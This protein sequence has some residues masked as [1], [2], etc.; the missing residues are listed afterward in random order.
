MA[1]QTITYSDKQAMG[2]Q[3]SIPDE[4]KVTDSDMNEIKSVVNN[5]ASIL[6]DITIYSSNEKIVGTWVDGTPIYRLAVTFT[7]TTM[8]TGT[9]TGIYT[10]PNVKAIIDGHF[11][12]YGG[13]SVAKWNDTNIGYLGGKIAYFS[14]SY[15][16][17]TNYFIVDYLK[18][19][20]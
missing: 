15:S 18:T 7:D 17:H 6:Q 19:T 3:P 5:N 20:D 12:A 1:I 4:N 14:A 11:G 10:M 13:S 2:T 8:A 9:W 16:H